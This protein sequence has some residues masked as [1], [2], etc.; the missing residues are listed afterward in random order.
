MIKRTLFAV[1][2]FAVATAVSL[3]AQQVP[4]GF[5]Y[6]G[7]A[8]DAGG[9]VVAGQSVNIRLSIINGSTSTPEY[10]ET[11][12]ATTNAFGL[13]TLQVGNGTAVTG[14]FAGVDWKSGNKL[15]GTEIDLGSGYVDLGSSPLQSVPYAL[16]AGGLAGPVDIALNDLSDVN[17]PLPSAG[18]VL[19]YNGTRWIVG[20]DDS[21]FDLPRNDSLSTTSL[22]PLLRLKQEG[23]GGGLV[24]EGTNA[25]STANI[26]TVLNSGQRNAILAT[27]RS[28]Q[29]ITANFNID[30]TSNGNPTL[31]AYTN[32]VGNA[33]YFEIN[34]RTT[35][36]AALR[37][38]TNGTGAGVHGESSGNGRAYGVY[39]YASGECISDQSGLRLICPTGVY[40]RADFGPGVFGYN[41]GS[42]PGVQA[43]SQGGHL[44]VGVGPTQNAGFTDMRF[45]VAGSG[46]TY[47]QGS[48]YTPEAFSSSR[49]GV[50]ALVAPADTGITAGDVLVVNNN[51]GYVQSSDTN[52]T[53]VVGVRIDNPA[54]IGGNP[55]D[56]DGNSTRSNEFALATSGI[57]TINVTGENGTIA[58]GDLLVSSSTPGHAMKA[59]ADPAIGTVVAKALESYTG[60]TE[61]SIKAVI[62]LR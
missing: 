61:G 27:T 46:K 43:F 51:G 44:F 11:H 45:H 9:A 15:L 39:G 18:Q 14:T 53:S 29:G 41:E 12:Q 26:L 49:M 59:P 24:L 32:G 6:Q 7:I 19:K 16:V 40:G 35:D 42:G 20:D 54:F 60:A 25:T 57:V 33:G 48:F 21:G 10:V 31:R 50:G 36:S 5:N 4:Q 34:N 3:Q 52:M 1:L 22:T 23:T 8:R 56:D 55:L 47:A 28:A 37:A 2:A 58:P 38:F 30:N 62:M 13:F 17:A